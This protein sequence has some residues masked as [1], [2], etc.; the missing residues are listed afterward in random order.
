[1]TAVWKNGAYKEYIKRQTV[2]GRFA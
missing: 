2:L 1:L